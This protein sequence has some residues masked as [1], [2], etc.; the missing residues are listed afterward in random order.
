VSADVRYTWRHG[1]AATIRVERLTTERK[2]SEP[3]GFH[4]SPPATA[5]YAGMTLGTGA[6]FAGTAAVVGVR[7]AWLLLYALAGPSG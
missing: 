6:A 3:A 4:E 2:P 5:L 7:I 1:F